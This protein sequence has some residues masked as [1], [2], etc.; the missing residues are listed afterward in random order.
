VVRKLSA[1]LIAIW[2]GGLA[3]LLPAPAAVAIDE[4]T[5][6]IASLD[7]SQFPTLS[8]VINVLDAGGR[9]VSGLQQGSFR[10]T[11]AGESAAITDVQTAVDSQVSLAVVLMVDVSGS[12]D[13]EPLAQA[14][15]AA[16]SFVESLSPQDTAAVL[17]FSDTVLVAQE[18][19]NDKGMVI[20]A[21]NRLQAV[22]NTA[23]Y[24][25]GSRAAFKAAESP[26]RRTVVILLSD[27]VDYGGKSTVSRADSIAQ[28][29][30]IGVPIYT[31]GLG[32]E[33]DRAYLSELAQ[34][35]TARFLETPTPE[36]LSQLYSEIGDL[37]RSQYVV[38]L[39]SPTADRSQPLAFE[40]SV[41][42]G[43]TTATAA[44]TLPIATSPQVEPPQV[45]VT[46]LLS[47]QEIDSPLAVTAEVVAASPLAAVDFLVD[48]ES[49]SQVSTPPFQLSLDPEAFT[50]GSHTL[51][52]EARDTTGAVG[53]AEVTFLIPALAAGGGG[54]LPVMPVLAVL[55]MSA[56][57]GTGFYVLWRRRRRV[58]LPRQAVEVR[59]RPWS[60]SAGVA[61]NLS[62]WSEDAPAD[63]IP[64]QVVEEPSGKLIVVSGPNAGQ[65]F[66]VG[67][68]PISI[69]SAGWC[70][71]VLPDEDGH[72]G[73]EEARA[74]VH[75]D[76]LMFHKLTR[77]SMLASEGVTGGW[78]VLQHG[79]EVTIG[80]YKLI[81]QL[82]PQQS[83][84]EEAVSDAIS[85]AVKEFAPQS[86]DKPAPATS[87][88]STVVPAEGSP[89]QPAGEADHESE[90]DSSADLAPPSP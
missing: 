56:L 41:T 86:A 31:I 64:P 16:A 44:E 37:L 40:L 35:T 18:F 72:I 52:V 4:L 53:Q 23:L 27:G 58:R 14:R 63:D 12:M 7:D 42:V 46:G 71:I 77:L 45:S 55:L 82:L 19:T 62:H 38:T 81:F 76:K 83:A 88:D 54:G 60:N 8:A 32:T 80:P 21:L 66:I 33:I 28:A 3:L 29:G 1:A 85:Q 30:F 11:I 2:L 87:S 48:G 49:V 89:I 43:D 10:A 20:D 90:G 73:P 6:D 5:I 59:L 9:P 74:W 50:P 13:G 24:E 68:K 39:T 78:F 79:D 67:T 51:R 34:A 17:T 15:T 70:A 69:G 36:G 84:E 57:G 65:E 26:S 47:G 22:G 61:V 75:K 25:A